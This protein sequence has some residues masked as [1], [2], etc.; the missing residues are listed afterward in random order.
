MRSI[1]RYGAFHNL[2][3]AFHFRY[4]SA[5][6][7][8]LQA[9]DTL[10]NA[11]SL[12]KTDLLVLVLVPLSVG[13]ADLLGHSNTTTGLNTGLAMYSDDAVLV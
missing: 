6:G 8:Q 11:C 5:H 12:A 4:T 10:L 13:A 1:R 2:I 7:F 9:A 3:S